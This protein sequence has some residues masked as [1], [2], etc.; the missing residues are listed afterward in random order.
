MNQSG[1]NGSQKGFGSRCSRSR[2]KKMPG[3]TFVGK[4]VVSFCEPCVFVEA[5]GEKWWQQNFEDP[6]GCPAPADVIP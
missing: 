3:P 1:F 5:G 2:R 4:N 6:I